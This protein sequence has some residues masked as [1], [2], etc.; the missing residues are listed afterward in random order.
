[1]KRRFWVSCLCL[2]LVLGMGL[3]GVIAQ[4]DTSNYISDKKITL[5]IWM[6]MNA[7][8]LG[9]MKDYGEAE[10]WQKI[11]ELTNVHIEWIH[12]TT[13]SE[14]E[15]FNLMFASDQLPDMIVTMPKY[16]YVAGPEAAVQDGYYLDLSELA[17]EY[18]PNYM[19]IIND[20][21]RLAKETVTDSGLR[22]GFNFIYKEGKKGNMGLSIRKDMLD[23]VGMGV[24]VTYDDWHKVLTAFKE[25]LGVEAPLF[26]NNSG[27]SE[28]NELLTGY[29]VGKEFYQVDGKVKYGPMEPGFKEYLDMMA[30]WYSE[31]LIDHD[32]SLRASGD[33]D[34]DLVLNDKVG[35]WRS[36]ATWCGQYYIS[37]GAT[38]P[39]FLTVGAP[40]PV[41]QVGDTTHLRYVDLLTSG[42]A[43]AINAQTQYPVECVKWLDFLYGETGSFITN[44]GTRPG[45]SYVEQPDGTF[46]WGT[47]ITKN[48]DGMTQNEART[49]YTTL[50]ALYEDYKRV[51]TAWTPEQSAAQQVWIAAGDEWVYPSSALMSAE[52]NKEYASIMVDIETY[53]SEYVV[54]SIMGAQ[55]PSYEDFLA[56][57]GRMGAARAV[58][59]KQAALDRYNAR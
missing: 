4:A 6:E 8:Q 23:R 49:K 16:Q 17:Q 2:V 53:V 3:P 20:N 30:Q 7:N 46:K 19:K 28:D 1:M 14:K 43:V 54:K 50:N 56:Q 42:W 31:G 11:E 38:N 13:G 51:T 39:D 24:P 48:P 5:K 44:Y 55:T 59:L 36:P 21:L 10:S 58:E 12:P 40:A 26:L 22:W 57:I 27:L 15:S 18:A 52:E 33:P 9:P 45:E 47:L 29:G 32:F 37:R 35:A 34:D 25:Q 41:K